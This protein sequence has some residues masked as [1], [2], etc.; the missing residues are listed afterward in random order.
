MNDWLVFVIVFA[1]AYLLGS[2]PAAYLAARWCGGVD[3]RKVGTRNVGASNVLHTVSKWVAIPVLLF[4]VGKGALAVLIARLFGLAVGIQVAA[5]IAAVVG[6]NWP[7]FLRFQGGRGIATSLGVV[8]AVSWP[9]GLIVLVGSYLFAPFKQHGLGVFVVMFT[10]PFL[11]WFFAGPFGVEER[12]PVTLGLTAITVVAF[13]R[14]LFHH[15]SELSHTTPFVELIFNRLFFDR[16]IRDR[17]LWL[18]RNQVG[19][20]S[21]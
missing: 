16:D 10:M 1:C 7:V 13:A 19:E 9:I 5:G 4:D 8:L 15:R 11:S 2:I 18:R 6:H 20:R 12:V 3:L 17:E 21:V 14:R